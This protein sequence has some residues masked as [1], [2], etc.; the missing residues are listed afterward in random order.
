MKLHKYDWYEMYGIKTVD[1]LPF[2]AYILHIGFF[3]MQIR[4]F[5]TS[6]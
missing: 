3:C 6:D 5:D 1:L 4:Q 2:D